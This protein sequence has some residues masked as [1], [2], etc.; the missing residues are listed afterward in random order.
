MD[1]EKLIELASGGDVEAMEELAERYFWGIEVEENDEQA[2]Y[3]YSIAAAKQS[4]IG[5]NGLGNCYRIGAGVTPDADKAFESY[6]KASD[7][8]SPEGD[9]NLANCYLSG[10]GAE[11]DPKKAMELMLRA[12]DGGIAEAAVLA[13]MN[14]IYGEVVPQDTERGH[15]YLQRAMQAQTPAAF[16]ALG[17]CYRDGLG[18][19]ADIDTAIDL[20]EMAAELHYPDAFTELIYI[21]DRDLSNVKPNDERAF[22][23]CKRAADITGDPQFNS[24]LALYY[25]EGRGT[26][27]NKLEA[28]RRMS[29]VAAM[30]DET[31]YVILAQWSCEMKDYEGTAYWMEQVQNSLYW[32]GSEYLIEANPLTEATYKYYKAIGDDAAAARWNRG[33]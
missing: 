26:E 2:F 11:R 15:E 8:G 7:A 27:V 22:F 12:A 3:W 30:G 18:V 14:L 29:M 9:Y 31:S 17:E 6:K 5:Y 20:F 13:G 28:M 33:F 25:Y 21:H 23:W 10:V 4:A 16:A 1:L 24:M 32:K 19:E